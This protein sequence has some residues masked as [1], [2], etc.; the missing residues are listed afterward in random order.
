MEIVVFHVFSAIIVA[1]FG[2]K[3]AVFMFAKIR[4]L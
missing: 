4:P 3:L 1:L 2:A